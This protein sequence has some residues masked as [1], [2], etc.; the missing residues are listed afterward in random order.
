MGGRGS[1]VQ[2]QSPR[3][4]SRTPRARAPTPG[5]WGRVHSERRSVV[6]GGPRNAAAMIAALAYA[7]ADTL[8]RALPE[9]WSDHAAR[10]VARVAHA[11]RVPARRALET[12]L[13]RLHPLDRQGLEGRSRQTFEQFALAVTD[14]LRL[15]RLRP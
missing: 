9:R 8:V 10:A 11:A 14:F 3:P 7:A 15:A 6:P 1:L 13:A 2:I 12:N 4:F 5:R